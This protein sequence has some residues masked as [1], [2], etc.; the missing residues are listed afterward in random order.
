MNKNLQIAIYLS[1]GLQKGLHE[2]P[3]A[4][5]RKQP[6]LQNIN[7]Y[8]FSIFVGHCPP[9]YESRLKLHPIRIRN[10]SNYIVLE[11]PYRI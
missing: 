1:L 2:K 4:L 5:K 3:S 7:F 11:M 10:T 9:G 6:A 8:D